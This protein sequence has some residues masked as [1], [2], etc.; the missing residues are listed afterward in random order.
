MAEKFE[1]KPGTG[2]IFK[3]RP[4]EGETLK[5]GSPHYKGQLLTPSGESLF[6]SMWLKESKKGVK[7]WS[8]AIDEPREAVKEE[9]EIEDDLP[10]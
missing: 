5:E 2:A 4:K 6:I 3:N 8:L 10:F 7:Y 9:S 1:Q